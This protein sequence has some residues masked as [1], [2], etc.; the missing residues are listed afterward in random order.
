MQF[1]EAHSFYLTFAASLCRRDNNLSTGNF[2]D[3][4]FLESYDFGNKE[5]CHF[6]KIVEAFLSPRD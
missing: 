2:E 1:S 3:T 5:T 6:S 4:V